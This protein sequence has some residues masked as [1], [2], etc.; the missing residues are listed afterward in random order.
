MHIQGTNRD[1]LTLFPEAIDDYVVSD[2][3]VRMI[4]AFVDSLALLSL[5]FDK[6]ISKTTGRPPYH[7]GDLLKLYLYG[8]LNRIRSS[9]RLET[10]CHRNIELIW[11]IQQLRPDFKTIADFRKDNSDAFVATFKALGEL[12]YEAGLFGQ[13]LIAIDGSLFQGVNSKARVKTQKK[14][15][16]QLADIESDIDRYLKELDQTDLEEDAMEQHSPR[17]R[18]VADIIEKLKQRRNQTLEDLEDL[19]DKG[20]SQRSLTDPDSRLI[21]QRH[22]PTVVGYNT[23]IAVDERHKLVVSYDVTNHANDKAQL[24]PMS[25]K[26]KQVLKTDQLEAVADAGYYN[27]AQIEQASEAGITT[28]VPTFSTSSNKT[29]GRYDRSQF[30]YDKQTDSYRCPAGEQLIQVGKDEIRQHERF[31][32]QTTKC[33]GCTQRQH[34]TDARPTRNRTIYRMDYE[35]AVEALKV[36]NQTKPEK[37]AQRKALVEHPFGT[38]KRGWGFDHFLVKGKKKVNAEMGLMLLAYNLKRVSNIF[39]NQVITRLGV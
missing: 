6:V 1:Q 5:G 28:Y 2:N 39:G 23:Q 8:Y 29:R 7:P 21:Q 33:R 30:I 10:E 26:A 31:A 9:R 17:P 38:I 24:A 35:E 18:D 22:K 25:I 19:I 16:L 4:D 3:T 37:Q 34:C 11:L 20:E 27:G 12:C 13:T 14:L 36:R 15:K 32:Y